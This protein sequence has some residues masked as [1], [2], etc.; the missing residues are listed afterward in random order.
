MPPE[1]RYDRNHHAGP[2]AASRVRSRHRNSG[3]PHADVVVHEDRGALHHVSNIS[4]SADHTRIPSQYR[5][6]LLNQD[7]SRGAVHPA[8]LAAKI[9]GSRR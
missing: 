1:E 9:Q 4:N 2:D 6:S 7:Q 8:N 3:S 5:T